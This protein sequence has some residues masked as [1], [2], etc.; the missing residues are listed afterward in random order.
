[1][2]RRTDG[3]TNGWTDKAGYRVACT[4]LKIE[5]FPHVLIKDVQKIQPIQK[6]LVTKL[7]LFKFPSE[8]YK[9]HVSSS[10]GSKVISL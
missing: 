6:K 1:M 9:P 8:L 2:D 3:R 4:R 7:K 10:I 5:M